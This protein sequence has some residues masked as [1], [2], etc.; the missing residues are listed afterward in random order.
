MTYLPIAS[1]PSL[2]SPSPI[3]TSNSPSPAPSPTRRAPSKQR[4]GWR[5]ARTRSCTFDRGSVVGG[6]QVCTGVRLRPLL[7][8][9]RNRELGVCVEIRPPF[10]VVLTDPQRLQAR[11]FDCNFAFDSSNPSS[12]Q[13]T[14]QKAVFD[15]LGRQV[16]DHAASGYNCCLCAYGQ[17]GAGKT[18][19]IHGDYASVEHRGLLPRITEGLF[20]SIEKLQAAGATLRMQ[21][22]YIEIYNK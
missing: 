1:R 8:N 5:S 11:S 13:Y 22:S 12:P 21:V 10:R 17:T 9:E 18:Y 2:R 3:D 15:S 19:T 20:A 7:A 6:E 4:S 16:V 14:D